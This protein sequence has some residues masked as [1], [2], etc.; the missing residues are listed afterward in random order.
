MATKSQNKSD[1]RWRKRQ[2]ITNRII[3]ALFRCPVNHFI[4]SVILTASER[5][6]INSAQTHEILG[7]SNR[8][9]FPEWSSPDE[10]TPKWDSE[11]SKQ[12][13]ITAG[14]D[15]AGRDINK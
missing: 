7:I 9:L 12:H 15:I 1:L 3:Y 5:G 10:Y 2:A 14:G 11:H 6:K 4:H 13:N 8:I